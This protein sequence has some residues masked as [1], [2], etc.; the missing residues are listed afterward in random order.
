MGRDLGIT[1]E[2]HRL[3]EATATDLADLLRR[4]SLRQDVDGILLEQPLPLH[5]P[6]SEVVYAIDPSKDVDGATGQTRGLLT[7][8]GSGLAPATPMA[9]MRLLRHYKV[10]LAGAHVVIVGHSPVVGKPLSL[11]MLQADATITVCHKAT[12]NLAEHTRQADIVVVATGVPGLVCGDMLKPGAT[13]VDVGIN[14]V[15]GQT[16]GDVDFPSASQVVKAI[17]PVPGGVGP[18]TTLTILENTVLSAERR[19]GLSQ[20]AAD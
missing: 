1:V 14:V 2:A 16:V 7:G 18:L 13:V 8:D 3:P 5:I 20:L 6:K 9:V 12:G 17:T 19:V 15:N 10:R 11:M 4:L